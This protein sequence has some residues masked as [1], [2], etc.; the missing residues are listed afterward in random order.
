MV[1]GEEDDEELSKFRTKL[2]RWRGSE[3]KERGVG[4]LRILKNKKNNKIRVLM[5]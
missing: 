3:W 2:Y 1:T 5:R 4:D